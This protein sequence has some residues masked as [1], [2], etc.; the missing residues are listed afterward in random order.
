VGTQV[1][2]FVLTAIFLDV[3]CINKIYSLVLTAILL[4]VE[5]INTNIQLGSDLY[6]VRR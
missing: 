5:C 1:D 6:I 4:D 2:S 3:E